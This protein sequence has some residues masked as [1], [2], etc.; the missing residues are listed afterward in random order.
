MVSV[1]DTHFYQTAQ[2]NPKKW[3][4][5]LGLSSSDQSKLLD[6]YEKIIALCLNSEQ[7]TLLELGTE[8]VEILVTLNMDMD[9]LNAALIFPLLDHQIISQEQ[10]N[11]WWSKRVAKLV[12]GATDMEGIRA[13]QNQGGSNN[14]AAQVD[15]LR[16][17]LLAMVDDVRAVVIKLAERICYLRQ[18]K[19]ADKDKRLL[20]ASE[21]SSIYAPLANRLGIG[22]LKWE[23]EDL[24]FRYLEPEIYKKIAKQLDEKRIDREHYIEN[25]VNTVKDSLQEMNVDGTAYG[26]PKHIYSIYRKM[27]KKNLQFEDLYDVRAV[28]VVVEKLQDC[29]A[30]LGA[31]HTQWRHIP[32][33]FDDYIANP[34]A[35]GYQS[36]HTVVLG[37]EGKAVEVQ[38][39]TR[40]MH[41]DSELGVAAHWKY[42]EGSAGGKASSGYEEKIA[43]LRKIL[44]WQEDI[45]DSEDLVDEVRSQVFDDRVYVFTPKGE[46]IDL[47]AGATPLDF[48]YYI[49]S[50]VG[51]RCIGAKVA[52]HI[53]PF[54]Y[55]LKTGDQVEILTQKE[56]NPSRDW[57]NPNLG[58]INAPRARN[59]VSSWF[60]KQDRDKNV[61]AGRELLENELAKLKLKL[62]DLPPAITRFN[63][64]CVEDIFAGVGNGDL[65]INQLLNFLNDYHHQQTLAEQDQAA[66]ESLA[67]RSS[68]F[69]AK[70]IGDNI[71]IQGESNLLHS[72]A[73]CCQPIPGEPIEGYI[74][75]G[76]GISVHRKACEQLADLREANPERLVE[77][78]WGDA[79]SSGYS[80]TLRLEALDRSGLL[81]DVSTLLSNEKVNVL[82]VNSMTNVKTQTAIIDLDLEIHTSDNIAKIQNKIKQLKDVLQVR[83]L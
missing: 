7:H 6:N 73:R 4:T 57:L 3:V 22:Q 83:R 29:Y 37:P 52:N 1:R 64:S 69:V 34:K 36:I 35:N 82:G 79:N 48:A 15:N 67:K 61:Q 13:L 44:A 70:P 63:V 51:H 54:T 14:N 42:K 21:I 32:S 45:A 75:Q 17:M 74:T 19:G 23:L 71:T 53:V 50:Q 39:R 20:V 5:T 26:R 77:A 2:K 66:L 60:R 25:F 11:E 27:Q 78:S 55:H 76:R 31:I 40:K 41:E 46:V 18:I 65:R 16:N 28:R 10:V 33:E 58:Y 30:A 43:W 12:K 81:R 49:H 62:S 72:I 9:T 38:I 80:L 59:K 68:S 47:P 8:M 24:S 56:P